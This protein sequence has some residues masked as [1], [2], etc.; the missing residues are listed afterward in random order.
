MTDS[1]GNSLYYTK[2]HEWIRIGADGIARTGISEYAAKQL[3]EVV[4]VEAPAVGMV[5]SKGN[6]VGVVES[7]KA[8]S[9]VFAPISGEVVEVN[10]SLVDS[11]DTVNESPED[12]GWFYKIKISDQVELDG[13]MSSES[14]SKFCADL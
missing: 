11:P 7:V 12:L 10:E 6:E 1:N 5:I 4:Y 8:A 13:L 14:Y 9:D 2:D 3:G